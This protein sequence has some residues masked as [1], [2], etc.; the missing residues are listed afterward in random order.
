MNHLGLDAYQEGRGVPRDERGSRLLVPSRRRCSAIRRRPEQPRL[1]VSGRPAASACNFRKAFRWYLRSAQQGHPA[2]Q[3]NL[4]WLYQEGLR[5]SRRTIRR[6]IGWYRRAARQGDPAAMNNLGWMYQEGRGVEQDDRQ[7]YSLVSPRRPRTDDPSAQNNIGWLLPGRPRRP[8]GRFRKGPALVSTLSAAQDHAPAAEQPRLD[9][10][11]RPRRRKERRGGPALVPQGAAE[12]GRSRPH[13]TI[14]A[15]CIKQGLGA[16]RDDVEA[17]HWFKRAAEQGDPSA[18]HNLG[19]M[20][21]SGSGVEQN[22]DEAVAW[23]RRAAEQGHVAALNSLGAMFQEGRGVERSVPQALQCYRE[24]AEFG[25]AAAQNN[26]G[27]LFR[28]GIGAEQDNVQAAE[29]FRKAAEQG[30]SNALYNLGMLHLE[31]LGVERD[32]GLAVRWLRKSADQDHSPAQFNLGLCYEQ[33]AWR[34]AGHEE[35]DVLVQQ[36][37]RVRQRRRRGKV[38][39]VR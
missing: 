24:A 28:D 35:G 31:G 1:D 34:R 16:D 2:A 5:R 19:T 15:T 26:L 3:N 27:C 18:Q 12:P 14:S 13:K 38:A 39:S 25:N 23:F 7:A 8:A 33:G 9:V 22:D 10:P 6:A 36:G 11:G 32:P 30:D 17:V 37:R 21:Q 29:W 20:Y 4:G